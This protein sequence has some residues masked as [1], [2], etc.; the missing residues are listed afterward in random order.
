MCY[1]QREAKAVEGPQALQDD[2]GQ[3]TGTHLQ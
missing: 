3:D 2:T 1:E